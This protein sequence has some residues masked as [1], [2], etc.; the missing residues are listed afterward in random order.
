MSSHK[1][2]ICV[3]AFRFFTNEISEYFKV[4]E[5]NPINLILLECNRMCEK[6]EN[7]MKKKQVLL[8]V[9]LPILLLAILASNVPVKAP[10]PTPYVELY[11]NPAVIPFVTPGGKVTFDL[12]LVTHGIPD[13]EP[14][15]IVGWGLNL[16]VD[17][18]VLNV[19][20]LPETFPNKPK[21]KAAGA[22]PGY[23]LYETAQ[24]TGGSGNLLAGGSDH[25][26]GYWWDMSEQILPAPNMGAGDV[27]SGMYKLVTV[28]MTSLS[29]TQPCLI[30][31]VRAVYFVVGG[32]YYPVEKVVDGFYGAQPTYMS[33]TTGTYDPANDPTGTTWHEDYPTYSHMWDL[34]T[35]EDNGDQKLSTSD[36]IDMENETGWI[37]PFH[38]DAVTTT[39]HWTFKTGGEGIT[40][41]TEVDFT[42][43]A[44]RHNPQPKRSP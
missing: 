5:V 35:W 31:I 39:I 27:L 4:I 26:T 20:L 40:E 3:R 42:D 36:Q 1:K 28:E 32:A 2:L 7:I 14:G 19:S 22:T 17:P 34:V 33:E 12:Y 25:T 10:Y 9:T 29:D 43:L 30:D 15:S 24:Y 21:A 11:T 23:L 8:L 37:Y 41:P 18:N 44:N 16:Q 38:V 13:M 6:G